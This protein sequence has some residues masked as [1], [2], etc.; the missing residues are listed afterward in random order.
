MIDIIKSILPWILYAI[1]PGKTLNEL[2]FSLTIAAIASLIFEYPYLKKGFVL[3]WGTLFFFS[4]MFIAVVLFQHEWIAK[5]AWIFSNGTLALIAWIS[6]LLRQ[7]FTIQYAKERVAS[8][9][10]QHPIFIKINNI[11]SATWGFIFLYAFI[12]N[13][14]RVYFPSLMHWS[15]ELSTYV[16]T[17]FGIWFSAWFPDWYKHYLLNKNRKEAS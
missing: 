8:D 17:G 11:L 12:L 14:L 2:K 16:L 5:H 4:F 3:S 10:W 13:I 7:P 6:I 9:K 15:L 1:L